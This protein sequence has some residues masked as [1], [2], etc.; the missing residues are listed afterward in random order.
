MTYQNEQQPISR[1]L[2]HSLIILTTII[3]ILGIVDYSLSTHDWNNPIFRWISQY[4]N[5]QCCDD[6]WIDKYYYGDANNYDKR[7]HD[8]KQGYVSSWD[9]GTVFYCVTPQQ[10]K[11]DCMTK[12]PTE[13]QMD[14]GQV[15]QRAIVLSGNHQLCATIVGT[16][17]GVNPDV[18]TNISPDEYNKM[19]TNGSIVGD[20]SN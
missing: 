9:S 3:V 6:S 18:I 17:V 13:Y 7:I 15:F 16:A 14:K 5:G 12:Y 20:G 11:Q 2:K 4:M 19:R 8:C 1:T 10:A